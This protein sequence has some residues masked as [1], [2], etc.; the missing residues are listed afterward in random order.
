M[1]ITSGALNRPGRESLNPRYLL[2]YYSAKFRTE[3]ALQFAYR[4]AILIW[5]FSLAMQPLVSIVV[6]TTVAKSQGGSAGG[7]TA[8]EYAA[9]FLILMVVN[10][11]TFMWH[12]WEMEWRVRTGFYSAILL[13]PM[14][15]IHN[16]LVE[17]VT[18]KSLT[19]IPLIPTVIVLSIVFDADYT[20]D[21]YHIIVFFPALILAA[22]LRFTMEWTIGLAAFWLTKT[23]ALNQLVAVLTLFLSGMIAP[24]A[25]LPGWAQTTASILPFRWTISFP[26]ELALGTLDGR[27]IAL[28]FLAQAIWVG[29]VLGVLRLIW[30]RAVRR[31][32]AV[33]A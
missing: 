23:S 14:H 8:G 15:P 18:F 21:L 2:A 22:I 6:W 9:Y 16:D 33:G 11:L 17:N 10:Q 3:L 19:L 12:M 24:L 5:L 32:S 1:A 28:G 13:R 4:G 25:L 29:I 27:Q 7:F 30:V 26:V 20:W 31:Y